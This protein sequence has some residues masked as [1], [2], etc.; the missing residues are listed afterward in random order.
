MAAT[1]YDTAPI[2]VIA[3]V[4]RIIAAYHPDLAE[5]GARVGAVMASNEGGPAVKV[6]RTAALAYIQAVSAKRRPNCEYDA[7][8]VIDAG[9]WNQLLPAQQDA[10]IDHE[11]L[12]LRRKEHSEKK[13]AKLRKEDPDAVAWQIDNLG[14]PKLGTIPADVNPGDGFVDCI[15]R[16]GANAVEFVTFE[17]FKVWAEAAMKERE[18]QK[19]AV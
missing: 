3:V 12:H 4:A 18:Q 10:L 8:I 14:R 5:C 1:T 6:H 16:H 2:E 19:A 17:K 7:E 15:L 9:E 11:L 13:L